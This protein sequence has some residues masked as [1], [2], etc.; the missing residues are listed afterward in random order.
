MNDR[1]TSLTIVYE[2]WRP[3]PLAWIHRF[4]A[5]AMARELEAAGLRVRLACLDERAP[6]ASHDARL[7]LRVSDGRMLALTRSLTAAGIDYLGPAADVLAR[8]YDKYA[9]IRRLSADGIDCPETGLAS[10]ALAIAPPRILKPRC[11]SDSIGVRPLG[12]RH[13]SAR[14]RTA[15][16]LV[17]RHIR[18]SELTVGAIRDRI[19]VPLQIELAEGVPY[20]FT[21]KY[22]LRPARS[23]IADAALSRRAIAL[24]RQGVEALGADWA[25]R[26]DLIHET[27]TDRLLVLECDAAPMISAQSAFAASLAAANISRA[28]QL[29]L[30]LA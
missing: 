24:A 18:G 27:A 6:D 4:E 12:T 22:L 14:K 30:L 3:D 9:A 11:G 21:R 5:R 1:S 16:F 23:P 17:Q 29:Q 2:R 10:D 26:V 7:L 15:E 13:V 28:E 19:G 25:V 20:S 8:C